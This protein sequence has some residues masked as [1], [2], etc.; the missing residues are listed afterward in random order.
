M[1]VIDPQPWP[2]LQ[3]EVLPKHSKHELSAL[4]DNIEL[5]GVLENG[6]YWV[7]DE[8]NQ[9]VLDGVQR[10]KYSDNNMKWECFT[11]SEAEALAQGTAL[12]VLHRNLSAERM[13]ELQKNLIKNKEVQK[14]TALTLRSKGKTQEEVAAVVGVARNTLSLWENENRSNVKT[15]IASIPEVKDLRVSIPKSQHQVIYE[16]RQAGET[17]NEIAASYNISQRRISQIEKKHEKELEREQAKKE[18]YET[19]E[20]PALIKQ[21]DC[22]EF[23]TEIGK[24]TVDLLLTDPPYS[25]DIEDIE[26]FVDGWLELALSTLKDTGQAYIFIGAYPNEVRI[27][28]NKLDEINLAPQI[29]VWEYKNTLG[30]TP[31]TQYKQNWQ[32]ILYIRKLSAPNL[33]CLEMIEQF[34][35][36][37]FN[38]PD[39]RQ[40]KRYHQW[41]KPID[42]A[43]RL[44]LHGSKE[45]D[46]MIDPFAGTGTFLLA[47]A[48]LGRKN[49]GVDNNEN[50]IKIAKDRGCVYDV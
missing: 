21:Q 36:Q 34:T 6:V 48:K 8:G 45:G 30:P 46:F 24:K 27:Y 3:D 28:L 42:L 13:K 39:A 35:V 11:G 10:K 50:M 38:A 33:N 16:R 7:D 37:E 49:I 29:L 26:L 22:L 41:E 43:E 5:Y 19:G 4:K 18:R 23:L 44:I 12:G 2:R 47:A 9:W 14:L 40:E 32:A 20:V 25:T 15:D 31:K 17:Q 1:V